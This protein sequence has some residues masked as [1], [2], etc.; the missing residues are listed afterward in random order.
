MTQR[1]TFPVIA[2][3]DRQS[4]RDTRYPIK[5]GH[6]AARDLSRHCRPAFLRHCRP[7]FLV[8]AGPLSSSLPAPTGNPFETGDARA[9]RGMTQARPSP[10]LPTPTTGE[11]ADGGRLALHFVRPEG[12]FPDKRLHF[13]TLSGQ[14]AFFR[15]KSFTSALCPARVHFP[16]LFTSLPAPTGNPFATRDARSHRA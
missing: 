1:G 5:P 6:D 2:G 16:G 10:S 7:A 14:R 12:I 11:D 4:L 9:S 8:I 13:G 15:T 3:A